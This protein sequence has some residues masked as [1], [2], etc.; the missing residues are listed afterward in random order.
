MGVIMQSG[1]GKPTVHFQRVSLTGFYLSCARKSAE[2]ALG[3]G[4][5]REQI[6]RRLEVS[7]MTILW[8][9]LALEA[10]ANENAENIIPEAD[11]S[12]FDNCR[13]QYKKPDKLSKIVW[14][15]HWLF[16][17][18]PKSEIPVTDPLFVAAE[19][20]VQLRHSITHYKPQ[21]T[22]RR[23]YFEPT[24]PVLKEDGFWHSMAWSVDMK[25]SKIEPSLV[26]AAILRQPAAK[27]YMAARAVIVRWGVAYGQDVSEMEKAFPAFDAS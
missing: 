11:L 15:W 20:L 17:A 26:E 22:A 19:E 18:G 3:I 9:T 23:V 4:D 16:K 10:G 14:K 8:A 25:P 1:G 6:E 7:I 21:D 24:P 5:E 12:A 27:H 13:Q 2:A